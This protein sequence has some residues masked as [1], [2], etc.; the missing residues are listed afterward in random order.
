MTT[1]TKSLL[2]ATKPKPDMGAA[3]PMMDPH[4]TAN[5]PL[6]LAAVRMTVPTGQP[7]AIRALLSQDGDRITA[8]GSVWEPECGDSALVKVTHLLDL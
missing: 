2:R 5:W 1:S 4:C 7:E 6:R 3:L 8:L